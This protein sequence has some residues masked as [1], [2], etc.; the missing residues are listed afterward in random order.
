VLN[1]AVKKLS[2]VEYYASVRIR[3]RECPFSVEYIVTCLRG[4]F[5]DN[6]ATERDV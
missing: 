6:G 2:E 5:L 3:K 4:N 1:L